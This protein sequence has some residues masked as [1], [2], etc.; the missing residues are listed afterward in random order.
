LLRDGR[1]VAS[2]AIALK[3]RNGVRRVTW[4]LPRRVGN[5][6]YRL[7]IDARA[8]D[9]PASPTIDSTS[10]SAHRGARIFVRR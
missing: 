5:G 3:G 7:L 4:R 2:R 6:H 1:Q 10:V 8:I 9:S